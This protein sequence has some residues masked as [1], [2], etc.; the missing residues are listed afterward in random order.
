MTIEIVGITVEQYLAALF[1]AMLF[2]A[3]VYRTTVRLTR[4]WLGA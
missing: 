1:C 4:R 3:L 2:H